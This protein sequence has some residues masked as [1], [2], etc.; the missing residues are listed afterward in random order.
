MELPWG[1]GPEG[2]PMLAPAL[3]RPAPGGQKQGF[4]AGTLALHQ[5]GRA[6]RADVC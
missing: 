4:Q 3:E 2:P 6:G 5:A 1:G